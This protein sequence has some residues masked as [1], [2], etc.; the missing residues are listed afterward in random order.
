MK[1]I[2]ADDIQIIRAGIIAALSEALDDLIYYEAENGEAAFALAQKHKADLIITDIK[3]PVCDG[4]MLLEKLRAAG[5][6]HWHEVEQVF[7]TLLEMSRT[8]RAPTR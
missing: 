5:I 2:I 1:L 8:L 3:M 6:F 7:R 4:L